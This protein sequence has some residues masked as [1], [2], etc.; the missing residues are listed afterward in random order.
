MK[1]PCRRGRGRARRAPASSPLTVESFKV[2]TIHNVQPRIQTQQ[3]KNEVLKTSGQ[4]LHLHTPRPCRAASP[5]EPRVQMGHCFLERAPPRN[6]PGPRQLIA[7]D[8]RTKRL[9]SRSDYGSGSGRGNGEG[10]ERECVRASE[11]TC[12]H[13]AWTSSSLRAHATRRLRCTWPH[14]GEVFCVRAGTA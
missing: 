10:G 12:C 1:C 11:V 9:R 6:Q 3:A 4:T 13:A 8:L 14:R 2:L 7:R 5:R